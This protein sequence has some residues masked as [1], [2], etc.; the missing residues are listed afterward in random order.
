MDAHL[1]ARLRQLVDHFDIRD[2][3]E[4]Y[5]HACDRADAAAVAEVY[6]EDS[7]DDHGPFKCTGKEFARDCTA[8]LLEKWDMCG[9]LLGQS[10]IKVDGDVAGAETYVYS[11]LTRQEDGRTMLDTWVG[12][13]IDIL[14]RRDGRWRIKNRRAICDWSGSAPLTDDFTRGRDL[15]IQGSRSQNDL[16]YEVLGLRRGS[17]FIAR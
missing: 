5:V 12:R 14:E 3:I 16:S 11:T 2:V 15:F 13:Y 8:A 1:E 17:S 7:W 4:T 9:H 10:R 6:Y